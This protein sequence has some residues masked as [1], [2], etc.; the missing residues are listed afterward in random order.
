M[1]SDQNEAY[2]EQQQDGS[3]QNSPSLNAEDVES[4]LLQQFA[5][6]SEDFKPT[7]VPTV[8]IC[9]TA[10]VLR[11]DSEPIRAPGVKQFDFIKFENLTKKCGILVNSMLIDSKTDFNPHSSLKNFDSKAA[12]PNLVN[13]LGALQIL[14]QWEIPWGAYMK[15][16]GELED[17]ALL[18]TILKWSIPP[19]GDPLLEVPLL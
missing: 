16:I 12:H 10:A 13:D 9:D 6:E 19:K 2:Q 17:V 8:S 18:A 11:K 5:E 7:K 4:E 15:D 14:N 1:K 3:Q